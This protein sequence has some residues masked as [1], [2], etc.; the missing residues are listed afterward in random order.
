MT[1]TLDLPRIA[2]HRQVKTIR[3]SAASAN[4]EDRRDHAARLAMQL[5]AMMGLDFDG[6]GDS[7]S[8][9]DDGQ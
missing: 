2:G 6:S 5:A 3:G 7:D 8:E 9:G 4:D 1:S